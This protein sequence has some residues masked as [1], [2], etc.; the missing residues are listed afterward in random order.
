MTTL[1]KR[2]TETTAKFSDNVMISYR[3]QVTNCV[4]W[5][6]SVPTSDH[7]CCT[8]MVDHLN[9]CRECAPS[10]MTGLDKSYHND[11]TSSSLLERNT[12]QNE[13]I[14]MWKKTHSNIYDE[15]FLQKQLTA[16]NHLISLLHRFSSFYNGKSSFLFTGYNSM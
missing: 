16:F 15:A 14:F 8:D 1:P 11:D 13:T 6:D 4:K 10:E 3:N 7:T 12:A 2:F 5:N 9:V